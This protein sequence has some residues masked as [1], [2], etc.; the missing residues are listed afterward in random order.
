MT[1]Q[2][3]TSQAGDGKESK[4]NN[5]LMQQW[6]QFMDDQQRML[7]FNSLLAMSQAL[8]N[9][10]A[11]DMAAFCGLQESDLASLAAYTSTI[12]SLSPAS[13]VSM[14]ITSSHLTQLAQIASITGTSQESMTAQ[15]KK[16]AQFE[17]DVLL[18]LMG[19]MNQIY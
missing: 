2:V 14:G 3:T 15:A 10:T 16:L 8:P 6:S 19:G 7:K 18:S 17:Q 11:K 12:T 1:G 13:M 5:P 4:V 9:M